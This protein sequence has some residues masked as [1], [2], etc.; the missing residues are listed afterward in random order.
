MTDL[1][2]FAKLVGLCVRDSVLRAAA[3]LPW[4]RQSQ[5]DAWRSGYVAG[6]KDGLRR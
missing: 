6:L 2:P 1:R 4:S 3:R 5:H